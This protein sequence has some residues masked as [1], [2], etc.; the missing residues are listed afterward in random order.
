MSSLP[1]KESA[2]FGPA[3]SQWSNINNKW[4]HASVDITINKILEEN[5]FL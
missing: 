2:K 4:N 5:K 1:T 3:Y